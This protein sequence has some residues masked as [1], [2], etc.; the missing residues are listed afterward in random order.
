[1]YV[2]GYVWATVAPPRGFKRRGGGGPEG[3]VAG[4]LEKPSKYGGRRCL[5][6]ASRVQQQGRSLWHSRPISRCALTAALSNECGGGLV[7]S[8]HPL[9]G[10]AS[11]PHSTVVEWV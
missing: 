11:Y 10:L 2:N 5:T 6:S 9:Q 1:M 7:L 4:V 8:S 3:G